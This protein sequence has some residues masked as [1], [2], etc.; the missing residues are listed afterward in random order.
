LNRLAASRRQP[1][2]V[3]TAVEC[4]QTLKETLDREY[5]AAKDE[6]GLLAY[7][8]ALVERALGLAGIGQIF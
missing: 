2:Q 8:K 3:G 4:L 7:A 5:E 1:T 6:T